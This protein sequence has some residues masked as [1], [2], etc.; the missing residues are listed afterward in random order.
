LLSTLF[1]FCRFPGKASGVSASSAAAASAP[2]AAEAM[3]CYYT[4]LLCQLLRCDV[5]QLSLFMFTICSSY[6]TLHSIAD[7]VYA[8]KFH[9]IG[10]TVL[11]QKC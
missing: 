9:Y 11:L 8:A 10:M 3:V 5:D 7:V 6:L 1:A 4:S 2:A